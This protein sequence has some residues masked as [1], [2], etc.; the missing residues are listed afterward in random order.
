MLVAALL[1]L[2]AK[3]QIARLE[4]LS[5]KMFK[6]AQK[7]ELKAVDRAIKII[8]RLDRYHGFDRA[9]PALEPYGE[10]ERERLLD[11]INAVAA[12]LADDPK[13]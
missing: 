9:S 6:R 13:E 3:L 2:F 1:H 8:E 12:R 4:A 11:K 5:V 7:G 10:E